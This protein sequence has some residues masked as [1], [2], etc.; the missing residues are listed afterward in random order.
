MKP[1]VDQ[2]IFGA[3]FGTGLIL[4]ATL[5]KHFAHWSFC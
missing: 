1:Y 4:A 5:F 2:L 3:L